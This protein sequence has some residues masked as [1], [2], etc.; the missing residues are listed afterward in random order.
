M[1]MKCKCGD[2]VCVT[3]TYFS[4]G[5]FDGKNFYNVQCVKCKRSYQIK[6]TLVQENENLKDA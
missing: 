4:L 5:A 3:K 1:I 2:D 6:I